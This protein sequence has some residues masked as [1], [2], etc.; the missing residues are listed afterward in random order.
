MNARR[1]SLGQW[2]ICPKRPF[3]K[4]VRA[5]RKS[6]PKNDRRKKDSVVIR[7]GK[8]INILAT[9]AEQVAGIEMRQPD[10]FR[11]DQRMRNGMNGERDAVLYTNFTHQFG[12]VRL[13]G[14]LFDA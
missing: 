2:I 4:A 3:E 13:Y 11:G 10:L 1:F 9:R 14:T 6:R 7:E 5:A 8:K 12:D